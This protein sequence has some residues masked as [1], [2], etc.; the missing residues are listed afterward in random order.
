MEQIIGQE[1]AL[2]NQQRQILF[3]RISK[4]C[5]STGWTHKHFAINL[6]NSLISFHPIFNSPHV[7]FASSIVCAIITKIAASNTLFY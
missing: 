3:A 4:D 5:F 1:I 2:F 7:R 6:R